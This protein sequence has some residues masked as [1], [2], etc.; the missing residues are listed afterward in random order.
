MRF[1]KLFAAGLC[2]T[3]MA[4]FTACNDDDYT[5]VDGAAPQLNLTSSH[6]QTELGHSIQIAGKVTD[7]DGISKINLSCPELLINKTI[8]IIDIYGEPLKEY[9][10]NY[11]YNMRADQQGDSFVIKIAVLDVAGKTYETDLLVTNDGDTTP[12]VFTAAPDKEIT[13]ILKPVT[14]F[15]LQFTVEDNR[16]VDYVEIDLKDITDGEENAKNVEGF[17]VTAQGNGSGLFV[18]SNKLTLP[19]EEAVLLA[20]ITAYDKEANEAPHA[21]SITSKVNVQPLPDFEKLYLAD[22][23]TSAELNSDVFGVPILVDHVGAYKYRARYYNEKAGTEICFLAQK[24]DFGP[25]CFGPDKSDS[26]VLGDDPEEV[27]KI[28]LDQAGVY[29]L[30]DFDTYE[31][32]YSLSTYPVSEAIDP[33]MHLHYGQDDLDTWWNHAGEEWWQ[34]F[35]FGPTDGDLSA[36]QKMEQDSKN[37][38]LYT[39]E[40]WNLETGSQ[41][42]FIIHNWHSHGW[43]NFATWR[44][45]NASDPEKFMYY[46]NYF[47]ET[48]HYRDNSDYF[49]FRYGDVPGFSIDSW[50]DE[51]YRKQFVPDNWVKPTVQVGG[52]YKLVF[53]AHT[54]RAKL[55]PQN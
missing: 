43:W 9:D 1:T 23:A 40:N 36:V 35:F 4:G 49:E 22:V 8:D 38:H 55:V 28:K 44:V 45:D 10:L 41:M 52:K 21:T 34:Q 30:I 13:V 17:P 53:D 14:T 33:V 15:N 47:P 11:K 29:Y 51:G 16:V 48:S 20:T 5:I 7:A 19:S 24:T 12:P 50:G 54:E 2:L 31:R 39:L 26:S 32:T 6:I 18:Y 25:I 42:N 27:N 3:A 46:G 37:P